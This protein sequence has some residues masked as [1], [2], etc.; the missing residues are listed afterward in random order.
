MRVVRCFSSTYCYSIASLHGLALLKMTPLRC[1]RLLFLVVVFSPLYSDGEV[2]EVC[3]EHELELSCDNTDDT[4]GGSGD[5]STTDP[6]TTT[7]PRSTNSGYQ[8]VLSEAWLYGSTITTRERDEYLSH[9]TLPQCHVP[10]Y[11]L[12]YKTASILQYINK[13][14]GGQV[15]CKFSL[16]THVPLDHQS[17]QVWKNGTLWVRYHCVKQTSFHRVCGTEVR[18]QEGWLKSVGYPQY[19]LGEPPVCTLTV[20]ADEGQRLQLTITDL[21]VREILQPT[22]DRCRDTVQVNEGSKVLLARCGDSNKPLQV[23]SEGPSLNVTLTASDHLFPKRGYVAHYQALGCPTPEVPKDGYLAFRNSTHAEFWCCVRHVFPDT[24]TRKK[25]LECVTRLNTWN[26]ELPDCIGNS[27]VCLS[28]SF[29]LFL[30]LF[31]SHPLSVC[32]VQ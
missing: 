13:E 29:F 30:F 3:I 12:Q 2:A 23:I 17:S 8:I 11:N 16:Q 32:V 18:S 21:S 27:S 10:E 22:E 24:M 4:N 26:E 7:T 31:L 25:V 28:V 19:Y 20:T 15:S 6:S 1:L 5:G 14:C 9:R